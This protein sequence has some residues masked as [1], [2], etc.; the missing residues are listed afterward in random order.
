MPAQPWSSLWNSCFFDTDNFFDN[1]LSKSLTVTDI[2]NEN[3]ENRWQW[4][5]VTTKEK[6]L[7][8]MTLTCQRQVVTLTDNDNKKSVV[9][10]TP[11][12]PWTCHGSIT[13][14]KNRNYGVGIIRT[15]IIRTT[16]DLLDFRFQTVR[17]IPTSV[18]SRNYESSEESSENPPGSPGVE[19]YSRINQKKA[20]K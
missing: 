15:V 1:D 12:H 11:A 7:E 6:W 9:M 18:Y 20:Q 14:K 10:P 3:F 16:S 8:K 4:Q 5:T 17:T 13:Q 2:D 19:S